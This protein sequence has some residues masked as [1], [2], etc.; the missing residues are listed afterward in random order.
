MRSAAL[1]VVAI[2]ALAREGFDGG[3]PDEAV[4]HIALA[5]RGEQRVIGERHPRHRAAPEPLLGNEAEA[6]RA[7][8]AGFHA[9]GLFAAEKDRVLLG[10]R[11]LT[12]DRGEELLLAVPRHAG[13]AD[14]LARVHAQVHVLQIG[15]E[16]IG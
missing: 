1:D 8:R 7:S 4:L 6:Q 15:A 9:P 12:R 3:K 5:M 16:R 2:D 10:E 13:D 11:L 14:D